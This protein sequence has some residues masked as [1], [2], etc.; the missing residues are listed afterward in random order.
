MTRYYLELLYSD[1]AHPAACAM[2]GTWAMSIRRMNKPFFRTPVDWN[3]EQI[4]SMLMFQKASYCKSLSARKWIVTRSV[5][6][7]LVS[8]LIGSQDS[9]RM[10][11][12]SSPIKHDNAGLNK[13]I[14]GIGTTMDPFLT[15]FQVEKL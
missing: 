8:H 2:L 12:A 5:L 7:E 13:L 10:Q 14:T 15:D 4:M 6:S 11:M 1:E 9:K 3:L